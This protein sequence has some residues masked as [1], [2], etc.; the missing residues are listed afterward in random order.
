MKSLPGLEFNPEITGLIIFL[1]FLALKKLRESL[2]KFHS[3][4]T[5][6]NQWIKIKKMFRSNLRSLVISNH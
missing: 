4:D 5:I 3:K 6:V 2:F 1:Y